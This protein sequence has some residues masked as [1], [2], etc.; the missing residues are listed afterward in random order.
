MAM[1]LCLLGD[2]SSVHVRRWAAEMA[3]RGHR[4]SLVTARPQD[5]P[6]VEQRLLSPV[7]RSS[8]S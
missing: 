1:H 8:V 6:G 5:L 4:V 2:A 7:A 3:A